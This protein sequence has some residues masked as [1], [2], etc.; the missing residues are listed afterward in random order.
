MPD[1]L[2]EALQ[3]T[4]AAMQHFIATVLMPL[5]ARCVAGAPVPPLLQE[6]VRLA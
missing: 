1:N 3:Q 4:R 5:H 2:P 6:E